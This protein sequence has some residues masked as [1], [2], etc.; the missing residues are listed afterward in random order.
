[1]AI[2]NHLNGIY[3]QAL[4]KEK[5]TKLAKRAAFNKRR[6]TVN[7]SDVSQ[8]HMI[9]AGNPGTGKMMAARCLAGTFK[10]LF[11]KIGN[12]KINCA[13]FRIKPQP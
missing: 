9:F 4:L 11:R 6:G 3:G 13:K 12:S 2:N 1:L 7:T 5:M 10:N 8:L